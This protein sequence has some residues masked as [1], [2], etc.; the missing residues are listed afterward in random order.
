[1]VDIPGKSY[2]ELAFDSS[3]TLSG[4]R[5]AQIEAIAAA[6]LTNLF[7]M[8][9]GWNNQVL[10]AESL[11]QG[12]LPK[13]AAACDQLQ[14]LG[15]VGFVGVVWPSI[16][17]PDRSGDGG[18]AGGDAQAAD[19]P[20][21]TAVNVDQEQSGPEIASYLAPAFPDAQ[22]QVTQLG[23]LIAAGEAGVAIGETDAVQQ[24]R[25]EQFHTLLQQTLTGTFGA[26]EDQG[27]APLL[28]STEP[29]VDYGLLAERMG[30]P[31]GAGDA[32]GL[33]DKFRGIWSG[34]KDMLRVG[35]FWEMKSRAGKIGRDGLGPFLAA[36]HSASPALRVHLI[37]H[38]FGCRLVANTLPA[39]ASGAD[40]PVAS[41]LL[42]QGAF[43]HWA[44]AATTPSGEQA[45]LLGMSTRVNGPLLATFTGADWAVGVWYPKASFLSQDDVQDKGVAGR[46]DGLGHDG[47]QDISQDGQPPL[48]RFALGESGTAYQL[49]PGTL[50]RVD[51]NSVINNTK[52]SA[53]AGAHSDIVKDQIGWLAACAARSAG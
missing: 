4:D 15:Q 52:Q 20:L 34:A 31:T 41:L 5:A 47:F 36:L 49:V 25:L 27:E 46:W 17:W 40:S 51:A 8:S 18:A 30:T 29:A 6:G 19:G 7:V 37:G 28:G 33:A 50:Y 24:A 38:S 48:D 26:S 1:M 14:E 22:S 13:V 10:D 9:H 12:L 16:W 2:F 23:A 32:Q 42:I 53:F 35:S 3:G 11:Y 39:F 45:S 43:S 44:F 21:A